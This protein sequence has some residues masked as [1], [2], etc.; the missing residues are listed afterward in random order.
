MVVRRRSTSLKSTF[1][2][3]WIAVVRVK[4][5][6]RHSEER[7]TDARSSL[8]F[9][10]GKRSALLSRL[11]FAI[12]MFALRITARLRG[13]SGRHTPISRMR[14]N[15]EFAIGRAVVG[16]LHAKRLA[17]SPRAQLRKKYY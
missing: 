13:N 8:A 5:K 11:W 9:S 3:S 12:K 17:A 1:N 6:S 15:T 7:K 4:A 10:K 16:H 14:P 2:E